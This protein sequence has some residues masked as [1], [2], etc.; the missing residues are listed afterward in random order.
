M[1]CVSIIHK[2]GGEGCECG[3][4]PGKEGERGV[5][6][7]DTWLNLNNNKK[8]DGFQLIPCFVDFSI[9]H[10]DRNKGITP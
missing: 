2:G 6:G 8:S 4:G 5:G 1:L 3:G 7:R 9:C 10:P